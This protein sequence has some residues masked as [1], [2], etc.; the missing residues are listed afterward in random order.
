MH[1]QGVSNTNTGP[2]RQEAGCRSGGELRCKLLHPP[3]AKPA[4]LDALG[5]H[6]G[7]HAA[8]LVRDCVSQCAA[9]CFN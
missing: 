9:C 7:V 8:R 2:V 5:V 1:A 4:H 6:H 3:A